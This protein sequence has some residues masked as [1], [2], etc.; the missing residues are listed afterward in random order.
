[1]EKHIYVSLMPEALVMTSSAP[2]NSGRTTR[3]GPERKTQGQAAFFEIDPDS[4]I[5]SSR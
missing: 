5:P 3:F 2:R 1:M 4:G